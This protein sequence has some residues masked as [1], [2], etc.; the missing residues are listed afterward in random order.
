MSSLEAALADYLRLR[1]SLGFRLERAARLL[2]QFL[3]FLAARGSQTVT[4]EAALAWAT[5]PE[6]GGQHWLAMRLGVV[7]CFAGHLHALD[8]VHEP[9]P[10][11]LLPDPGARATPYLYADAEIDTGQSA[12]VLAIPASAII[13]SGN[14]Q[15]A[16][17]Q[18]SEGR[19]KPME[20]RV[21]RRGAG[22]VEI[23]EGLKQGEQVVTR[24]NFLIDAESNL[25][26]ALTGLTAPEGPSQ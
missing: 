4:V 6:S 24:A 13:D 23:L 7:R 1:R 5:L 8:P 22:Y 21:G 2:A 16:I 10:T 18:V 11:D 26:A 19:F 12:G 20:V 17:V 25:Q 14:R 3:A 9:I 15:V